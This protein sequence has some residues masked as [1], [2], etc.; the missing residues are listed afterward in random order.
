[1]RYDYCC[2]CACAVIRS[3]TDSVPL[4]SLQ[5]HFLEHKY[6][7]NFTRKYFTFGLLHGDSNTQVLGPKRPFYLF[8]ML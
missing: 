5:L 7:S 2:K 4:Q 8:I 6:V 1:M 3:R